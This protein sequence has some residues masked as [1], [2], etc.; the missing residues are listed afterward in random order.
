VVLLVELV[1][2]LEELVVV[3]AVVVVV[4]GRGGEEKPLDLSLIVNVVGS[5]NSS[6][7]DQHL[8]RNSSCMGPHVPSYTA[9]MCPA[10]R[11]LLANAIKVCM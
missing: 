9:K 7:A 10:D 3:V 2:V 1:V 6:S 4:G 11:T 5:S 8:I